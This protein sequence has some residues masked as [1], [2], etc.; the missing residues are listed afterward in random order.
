MQFT[1]LGLLM[2]NQVLYICTCSQ[3]VNNIVFVVL[4]VPHATDLLDPP[5]VLPDMHGESE[6]DLKQLV[7]L[8]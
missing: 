8:F 2:V 7:T 1:V 3:G 4:S 6:W 5:V